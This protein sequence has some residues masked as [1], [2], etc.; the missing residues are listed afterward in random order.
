MTIEYTVLT[1]FLLAIG[2]LIGYVAL[3]IYNVPKKIRKMK[4]SDEVESFRCQV[5]ARYGIKGL[6]ALPSFEEMVKDNKEL[7]TA[8]YLDLG[9]VI[10]KN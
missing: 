8:N 5:A 7:T 1:I 3:Q 2:I 6:E 10:N 4:R 9:K